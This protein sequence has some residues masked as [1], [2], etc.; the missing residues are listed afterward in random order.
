MNPLMNTMGG[1]NN[2]RALINMMSGKSPN[3]VMQLLA[4][5]NPQ[6]RQFMQ[7]CQGKTPEQVCQEYGVDINAV[8][9]M[10]G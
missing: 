8:K 4:Q 7:Q 2:I 6:F 3:V 9:Q 10:L 1:N 5:R